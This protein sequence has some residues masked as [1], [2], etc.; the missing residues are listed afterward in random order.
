MSMEYIR[1]TYSVPAKRGGRV[2]YLGEW[3]P[4]REG[5]IVGSRGP[6]LR[7]RMKGRRDVWTMHPTWKLEYL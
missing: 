4:W 5:T 6:Y 3:G 7:C 2:R 1:R